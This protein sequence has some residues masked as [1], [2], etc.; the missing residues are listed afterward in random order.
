VAQ[1][2]RRLAEKL[3]RQYPEALSASEGLD[4]DV[5]EAACL[6]HDLGHPPFGHV[7]EEQLNE[8]SKDYGGFE[9]NAQTFRILTKLAF[10]SE[11]HRGLDLTRAT[12]AGVLKYP[13]LRNENPQK[14]K[15]GR[16]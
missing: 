16:L 3:V 6:A 9:G 10:H 2:G 4:P 15:M 11:D 1:V 7:A 8:L 5:V 13:W 12:L 14:L